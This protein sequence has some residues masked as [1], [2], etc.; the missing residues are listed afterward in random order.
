MVFDN[1]VIYHGDGQGGGSQLSSDSLHDYNALMKQGK[2]FGSDLSL[3]E[4]QHSLE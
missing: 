1:K 2:T 4:I 3:R